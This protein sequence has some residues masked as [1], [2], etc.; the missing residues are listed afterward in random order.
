MKE[1]AGTHFGVNKQVPKE[2]AERRKI[3]MPKMREAKAQG[4]KTKFIEDKLLVEGRFVSIP[5]SQAMEVP[6]NG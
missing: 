3:L 4:K 2:W 1:L 5:V 6:D